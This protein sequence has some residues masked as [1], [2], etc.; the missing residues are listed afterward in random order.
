MRNNS[1]GAAFGVT[2]AAVVAT[3]LCFL[4]LPNVRAFV[5]NKPAPRTR[6]PSITSRSRLSKDPHINEECERQ[7][8]GM[9]ILPSNVVQYTQVPKSG[10]AFTATTIPS[11]LTKEHNTKKGTWGVIR[12]STGNLEY[13]I[14]EPQKSVHI[15]DK[16]TVGIIEPTMLHQVKALS[17]DLEFVVEF[18]RVPGS[19]VVDEKREGLDE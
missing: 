5:L 3:T 8:N 18:W 1:L 15:L 10:K 2:A 11:G 13:T 14:L 17:D 4:F 9:P 16:E 12:V 7:P 19:G 6:K